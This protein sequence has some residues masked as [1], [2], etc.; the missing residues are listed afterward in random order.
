MWVRG[1]LLLMVPIML[2]LV[3]SHLMARITS[4]LGLLPLTARIMLAPVQ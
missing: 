4:A 1:R 3:Q 2:A